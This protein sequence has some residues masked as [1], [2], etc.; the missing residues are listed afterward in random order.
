MAS[1]YFLVCSPFQN[2]SKSEEGEYVYLRINFF[3]PGSSMGRVDGVVFPNPEA[4]FIKEV[5]VNDIFTVY[6]EYC[7]LSCLLSIMLCAR[8]HLGGNGSI[9]LLEPHHLLWR[10]YIGSQFF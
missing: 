4:T 7:A 6:V 10:L 2:I 1:M 8:L 9:P 5:L 3:H